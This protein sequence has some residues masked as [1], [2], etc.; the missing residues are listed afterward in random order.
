MYYVVHFA[1]S[2]IQ[3]SPYHAPVLQFKQRHSNVCVIIIERLPYTMSTWRRPPGASW[4]VLVNISFFMEASTSE[5]RDGSEWAPQGQCATR[6]RGT[7]PRGGRPQVAT[8]Y[9]KAVS[10]TLHEPKRVKTKRIMFSSAC[11]WIHE[12][13]IR[14]RSTHHGHTDPQHS[15]A[16]A[17]RPEARNHAVPMA[18]NMALTRA[19]P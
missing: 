1:S 5:T 13:R 17:A 18:L 11:S 3:E 2:R 8:L 12:H 7:T 6:G 10:V 16:Q 14:S 4:S 9:A 15:A 19:A